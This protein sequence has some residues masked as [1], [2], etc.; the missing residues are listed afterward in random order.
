MK[1]LFK[2]GLIGVLAGSTCLAACSKPASPAADASASDQASEADPGAAQAALDPAVE[3]EEA[4]YVEGIAGGVMISTLELQAE[5]VSIN[6]E[7]RLAVVRGPEGNEVTL[8][9]GEAA[10]N[11]YQLKAGDRVNVKMARELVVFVPDDQEGESTGETTEQPD[12]TVAAS[13]SAEEGAA[14]AGAVV[15][16]TKV[17]GTLKALDTEARTATISFEDGDQVFE[18]RPDVDMSRYEVGQ[19]VVFLLTE[20]LAFEVE[21]L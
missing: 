10:V 15:A 6:Q 16:S 21:S 20:Y 8:R 13:A 18:V 9:V 1:N 17:T 2:S 19:E 11:V 14:P 3:D 4:Y 7:D 12:G 5:I